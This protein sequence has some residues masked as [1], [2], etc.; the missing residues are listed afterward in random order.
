MYYRY[1]V[2]DTFKMPPEYFDKDIETVAEDMLQRKYEGAIDKDM[3]VIIAITNVRNISDGIIYPGDPT[4]H[5]EVEFDVLTYMPKV[6]EVVVGEV[7]ELIDFGAFVR[8]GP[9][10]GLVH[11]SQ[12]TD[13]FISLDKKIPALVAKKSGLTLKKGDI[14]YAR[15]STVSMKNSVKDSKIALTMKSEGLGKPEWIAM[16]SSKNKKKSAPRG[17]NKR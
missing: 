10:E 9:L 14:I 7:T 12:I 5:H 16:L 1:S 6:D 8:I 4:T 17:K 13:E 11:V 2:K 15:I 3:G